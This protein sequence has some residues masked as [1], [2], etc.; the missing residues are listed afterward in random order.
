MN[1]FQPIKEANQNEHD[2]T[3]FDW[4]NSLGLHWAAFSFKSCLYIPL[5]MNNN[6]QF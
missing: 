2:R 4:F 6:I 3:S 1:F 5:G